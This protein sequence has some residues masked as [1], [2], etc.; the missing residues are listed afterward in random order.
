M[1]KR[2]QRPSGPAPAG[3]SGRRRTAGR[4]SVCMIVRNE[5]ANLRRSLASVRDVADEIVVVDTGSTDDTVAVARTFGARVAHVAWC[6]DFAAARNAALALATCPWIL[7]LDADEELTPAGAQCLRRLIDGDPR[8]PTLGVVAL[9]STFDTGEQE[10]STAVRLVANDPAIRFHRP[11]HEEL[12]YLGAGDCETVDATEIVINHHGYHLAE[13]ERQSKWQRNLRLLTG[14]L[15]RSPNDVVARYYLG[16]EYASQ[17]RYD[18]AL[19]TLDGWLEPIERELPRPFAVRAHFQYATALRGRGQS[20]AAGELAARAAKRLGSAAL[21]AVAS[22]ALLASGRDADALWHADEAIR[23]AALREDDALPRSTLLASA[24]VIRGDVAWRAGNADGALAAYT[25]A[26]RGAPGA[27]HPRVRLAELRVARG[28]LE[29]AAQGLRAAL[30]QTPDDE[31]ATILLGKVERRLGQLQAAVDRLADLLARTP[32]NL[33]LRLEL[34]EALYEGKEFGTGVDVLCA[35]L[36]TA[37]LATI[38]P[39]FR[40]RYYDRLGFGF[41]QVDRLTEALA[42]YQIAAQ[43][44]PSLPGPRAVLEGYRAMSGAQPVAAG[45]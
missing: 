2:A 10:R 20:E 37:Q 32:F 23:L 1:S 21:Y 35:A 36:E 45:A 8:H 25:E 17:G 40:G 7:S 33:S 30:T 4:L 34:A 19:A 27:S 14:A 5:S 39:V 31:A 29:G 15:E 18:E 43:A 42:A 11:I 16:L 3:Q 13:R 28:D 12:I 9:L 38:D 44:D 22:Q 26:V 41:L 24:R 6:D